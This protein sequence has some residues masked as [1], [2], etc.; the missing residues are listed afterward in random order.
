VYRT[1]NQA[2]ERGAAVILVS[3][4]LRAIQEVCPRVVWLDHG[5]AMA[6]G[7]AE[8]VVARYLA[9]VGEKNGQ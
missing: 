5:Q 8:E 6:D 3:H 1:L 4:E 7:P 9:S 2:R